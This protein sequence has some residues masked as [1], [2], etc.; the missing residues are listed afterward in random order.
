LKIPIL[1]C[2]ELTKFFGGLCALKDLTFEVNE[3]EL[4]CIIGPNGSGKTTLFNCISGFYAPDFGKVFFDGKDI[5]GMPSNKV[6]R[7]GLARTFQLTKPFP[8]LTVLENVMA[9]AVGRG[10]SLSSAKRMAED[11]LKITGLLEL[12]KSKAKLL[13]I[14]GRKRLELARA[15]ATDPSLLLLDEPVGGLNPTETMKLVDLIRE[16]NNKGITIILVEHVMKAVVALAK[17]V[18]VLHH[19]EKLAEGAMEEVA[20]DVRVIEAYLGQKI[21]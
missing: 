3:G 7:I 18:I 11:I 1:K 4:L 8:N 10:E 21:V 15:L 20:S 13:N 17:R 12:A 2:V 6:C 5:T 19:G 16:I 9:G 14:A